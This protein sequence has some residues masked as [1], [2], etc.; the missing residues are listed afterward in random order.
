MNWIK[1]A[2]TRKTASASREWLFLFLCQAAL[3]SGTSA[4]LADSIHVFERPDDD[5]TVRNCRRRHDRLVERVF[6]ELHILRSGFDHER[7]AI[8]AGEVEPAV[9]GDRGG[10]ERTATSDSRTIE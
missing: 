7:V 5:H 1:R 4:G 8:L 2:R 3:R 10:G 6:S 9:R